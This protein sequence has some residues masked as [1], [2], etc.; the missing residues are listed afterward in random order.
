MKLHLGDRVLV[1]AGKDKGKKSEVIRV[2]PKENKVVVKEVNLYTKHVKP[3]GD[4][5]GE[6][7]RRERPMDVAKVAILN[8]KDQPDRVGYKIKADGTKD[9]IFK[10]TGQVIEAKT[11]AKTKTKK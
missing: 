3:M 11:S 7:V 1:T 8:D 10:K 9:R 6:K 5:P 2:M 4:R